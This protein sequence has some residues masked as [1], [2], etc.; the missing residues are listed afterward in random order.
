MTT[1]ISK[2]EIDMMYL[3][4][5][6]WLI[7]AGVSLV[8]FILGLAGGTFIWLPVVLAGEPTPTISPTAT[9]MPTATATPLPTAAPTTTLIPEPKREERIFTT[10]SV[11]VYLRAEAGGKIL[12]SVSNGEKVEDLGDRT[13]LG[14]LEWTQ[15]SYQGQIGWIGSKFVAHLEE[16]PVGIVIGEGAYLRTQPGSTTLL[17]MYPGTPLIALGDTAEH[18]NMT[19]QEVTL[20]D[21][22][23]GWMAQFLLETARP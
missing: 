20:P 17:F 3:K 4:K 2:I 8:L 23:Q 6:P 7:V 10:G 13:T 21:G 14:G 22:T 15:V 1:E 12:L 11:S 18:D 19:W 9:D 5:R 16:S